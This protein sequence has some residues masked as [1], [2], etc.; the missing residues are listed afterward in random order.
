MFQ[1]GVFLTKNEYFWLKVVI[2][3][4]GMPRG[5]VF[6]DIEKE[7]KRVAKRDGIRESSRDK[8]EKV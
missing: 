1:S 8:T 2:H 7:M 3:V 4:G 5:Y 6:P